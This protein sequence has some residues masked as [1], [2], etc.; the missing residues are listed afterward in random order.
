MDVMHNTE[1]MDIEQLFRSSYRTLCVYAMHYVGNTDIAEDV[2]MD[3]FVRFV[4][5]TSDGTHFASP[6]S[7]LYR[8]VRNACLD[9]LRHDARFD[10]AEAECAAGMAADVSGEDDMLQ[11]RSRREARLWAEI[12]RLPATCRRVLL[13]S[14]RDNMHN[15]EIADALGISIKTVEAHITKAYARLRGRA[16]AIYMLFLQL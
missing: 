7:Y 2:V 16:A 12:D 10:E 6:G 4:E 8:M 15:N 1:N 13:M 11:E 14:K 5:K 9:R 3:C